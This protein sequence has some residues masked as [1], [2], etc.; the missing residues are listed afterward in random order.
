MGQCNNKAFYGKEQE[1]HSGSQAGDDGVRV[2]DSDS[3][4]DGEASW[5]LGSWKRQR[6]DFTVLSVR[7]VFCTFDFFFLSV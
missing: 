6:K 2:F 3:G 4:R 5:A 7:K 1:G